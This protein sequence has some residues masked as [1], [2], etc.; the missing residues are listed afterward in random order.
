M[1]LSKA[2]LNKSKSKWSS[3]ETEAQKWSSWTDKGVQKF[4]DKGAKENR[5]LVTPTK[6][7]K[8]KGKCECVIKFYETVVWVC[9]CLIP[10]TFPFPISWVSPLPKNLFNSGRYTYAG[11]IRESISRYANMFVPLICENATITAR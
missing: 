9:E 3:R 1:S 10:P 5:V 4:I 7:C 8:A 2:E 6:I 11:W